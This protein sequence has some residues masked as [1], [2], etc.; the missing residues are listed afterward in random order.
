MAPLPIIT[1]YAIVATDRYRHIR[2]I[3]LSYCVQLDRLCLSLATCSVVRFSE[4]FDSIMCVMAAKS[5]NLKLLQLT[6]TLKYPFTRNTCSAAAAGG[7]LEELRWLREINTPWNVWTCNNAAMNGHFNV[8]KWARENGCPW[9][10][11]TGRYIM[12][13]DNCDM[14]QWM[15]DTTC[16]DCFV[17][18]HRYCRVGPKFICKYHHCFHF[19]ESD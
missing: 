5:G 9:D 10:Q 14:I 11:Y 2:D 3:L 1:L 16:G 6:Y 12:H 13:S 8:L 15:R 7:Y 19:I 18:D 4:Q 17:D